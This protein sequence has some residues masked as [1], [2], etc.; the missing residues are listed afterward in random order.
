MAKKSTGPGGGGKRTNHNVNDARGLQVRVKTA[1]GRKLSSTLW[2]QRQLNDPYVL[3]A[4]RLG[5]RGRAA[6]KL[7][8][9][10]DK[11]QFLKPNARIVDL[12]CAPGGWTQV[13][14]ERCGETARIVGI[15]LLECDPIPGATLL[16]G[17]FMD[18]DAPDRLKAVLRGQ[19]DIVMSDMA[20]NT[21]G[22]PPTDHLRV[23]A[24]VETAYHF[25]AEV[26]APNG[27]FIAKVFSGG[28]ENDLL[29]ILKKDFTKVFH[30]KPKSSRKESPEMYVVAVGFRRENG[31]Q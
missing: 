28:T 21:T 24:L 29:Q 27:T 30:M 26:L 7:A 12:G 19:A 6:F 3:E 16:V 17:D 1:R 14:L 15:D 11:H 25:A 9:I 2:L 5:Y 23:V 22:H 4:Q 31:E 8:E 18:D 13:A 20:S 10:D